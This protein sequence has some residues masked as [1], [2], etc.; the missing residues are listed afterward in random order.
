MKKPSGQRRS[1][2]LKPNARNKVDGLELLASMKPASAKL[3]FIDPQYRGVLDHQKYGNEGAR[4]KG[5]A[6]LPQMTDETIFQFV[7]AAHRVLKPSGHLV[8]WADKF[9]VASCRHIL[10]WDRS[11]AEPVDMISWNKTVPGMGRRARCYTEFAI[12][13]QKEPRRAK[14]IWTDHGIMD[15]WPE[16]ADRKRHP[17]AK[18][19]QLIYRLIRCVTKTGD[20]VVDPCAGGYGV[21]DACKASGRNFM[22]GDIVDETEKFK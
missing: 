16:S 20:L 7:A 6:K 13:F 12:I 18:P 15:C 5:R 14:G 8:L 21:L 3:V 2:S 22:G 19:I 11:F 4:Q 17:H 1:L 10:W 9:A